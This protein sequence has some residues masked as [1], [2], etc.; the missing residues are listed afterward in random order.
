MHGIKKES[1][2]NDCYWNIDGKCT[3]Q[4]ITHNDIP[5][6]FSRDWDSKQN[7]TLTQYGVCLCSGYFQQSAADGCRSGRTIDNN[8]EE[9]AT[10]P[11]PSSCTGGRCT[12]SYGCSL[13]RDGILCHNR[14]W[15]HFCNA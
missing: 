10:T 15:Q 2:V 14:L 11:I 6:G 7:C 12:V 13:V 3:N 5:A 4:H 1:G 9:K 8:T